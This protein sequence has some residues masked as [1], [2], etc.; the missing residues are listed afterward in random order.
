MLGLDLIQ[1]RLYRAYEQSKM[2]SKISSEYQDKVCVITINRPEKRNALDGEMF[3]A[4]A[5]ALDQAQDDPKV[6]C[7]LLLGRGEHFSAGHDIAAF[8]TLWPQPED[9]AVRRMITAFAQQT[10]PLVVAVTGSAIGIGATLLLHADWIVAGE[11]A[12][13]KFPFADLGIVP[14]AGSTALLARRV[15]DLVTRDWLLSARPISATEA[16]QRGFVSSVL[17]DSDVHAAAQAYAKSLAAK[18]AE[19]LRAS[20]RLLNEASTLPVSEAIEKEV[21]CLNHFIPALTQR[22]AAKP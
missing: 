6:N 22:S 9:G 8:A 15:G 14:E 13:F 3:N 20:R 2:N 21:A 7:V 18:P 1:R 4:L 17:P 5:K 10:K 12:V 16:L 19:A 11:T